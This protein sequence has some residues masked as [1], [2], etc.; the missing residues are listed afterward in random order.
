MVRTEGGLRHQ[1]SVVV[2]R[3]R[4]L[5][6]LVVFCVSI[7]VSAQTRDGSV[8]LLALK[9]GGWCGFE[10]ESMWN[11]AKASAG[12][13]QQVARV[14]YENG[15][16]AFV[17]MTIPDE[18]GDWTTYDKYTFDKNEAPTTLERIIVIP[19]G[20][21]QDQVWSIRRGHAMKQK[22][23]NLRV[24]GSQ[25]IP[26]GRIQFPDTDKIVVR[27]RDFPFWSLVHGRRSDIWAS[28][29]ACL[30]GTR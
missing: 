18:T 23:V 20:F 28:G 10:T 9:D 2:I 5:L 22:S 7:S 27:A 6:T 26:D 29:R 19:E 21:K 13:G 24:A 15:R 16:A 14:D 3:M 8:Y 25:V 12:G 11:A 30:D 17:Y 4:L 1:T